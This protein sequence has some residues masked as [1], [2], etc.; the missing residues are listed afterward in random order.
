VSGV[1]EK[2][3]CDESADSGSDDDDVFRRSTGDAVQRRQTVFQVLEQERL[4]FG[5]IV[6]FYLKS[7]R[8]V[9][10]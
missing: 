3:S 7:E 8:Q 1:F 10:A 9:Q 6:A 5:R 2:L 4:V